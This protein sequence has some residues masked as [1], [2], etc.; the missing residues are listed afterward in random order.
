LR[1]FG[2]TFFKLKKNKGKDFYSL[3]NFNNYIEVKEEVEE[4]EDLMNG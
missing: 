3:H 1:F 4:I 2:I